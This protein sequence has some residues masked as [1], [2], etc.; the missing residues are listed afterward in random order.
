MKLLASAAALLCALLLAPPASAAVDFE[1]AP[2]GGALAAGGEVVS[3]ALRAPRAFNL[4]GL[5]WRGRAL[6]DVELRVRRAER[7]SR[8]QHLGVHGEGG[9]DP[10]WVGRAR[11]VQ[12]KLD[13]PVP[14]LRLH[15]VNVGRTRARARAS[16]VATPFPYVPREDWG[17]ANCVPRD[18][19]GY[20]TVKA[21]QVHHTVS[22]NDYTRAEA[23]QIV[24]AICR[25]HRNSNG[26]ND[27]GYNA[28]VDK[29][30]TIY[31]GRAGGLDQAV[32]GAHAQGF[33][34]QTAGIANIGDY[35]TVGASQKALA[36]TAAYIRWKLTVHGEPLSGPVTLTSSG[37]SAS[38]YAAGTRVTL[39]RVIGHRDTGKTACP[40]EALYSQLGDIRAMV[41]SGGPFATFSSRVTAALA[42]HSVDYGEPVP[43][44]GALVGADGGPLSGQVVEVQVNSDGAWRTSRRATTAADGVFATELKPARRM[45]V[46]VRYPGSGEVRGSAS[47]QQLLR[48]RP[49]IELDDPPSRAARGARVALSGTVAPRKRVVTV[50]LQQSIRGRW[51]KVGTR[52]V[53][54]RRGRFSSSFVP[55]FRARYRYYAVV[56]SDLDTDRGASEMQTL[57]V[58]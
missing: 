18:S 39:E 6:P 15:F 14:G 25:Y 42:D 29:Y 3:R 33:N 11:T 50:V 56:R 13:R 21:V 53:R 52:A 12:Y 1:L 49:V 17:A 4:V 48:L 41:G 26:W 51:R 45:Y 34:S 36:S 32:V 35:S 57:R 37:G 44:S 24:L 31:E 27:I 5:R 8:W 38:R 20:G 30:G 10:V 55:G 22:L 2:K 19:P 16:Q 40:G 46:R 54:A 23:P 43:V 58:R 47:P 7:W 9:S 28:L